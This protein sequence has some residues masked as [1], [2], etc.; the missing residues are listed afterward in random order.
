MDR[1][2][3]TAVAFTCCLFAQVSMAQSNKY[4][5]SSG[6]MEPHS[7]PSHSLAASIPMTDDRNP[8]TFHKRLALWSLAAAY[9]TTVMTSAAMDDDFIGT[10]ALPVAGPW[11][12]MARI[13][14]GQGYYTN[15]GK[16]LLAAA[17]LVQGGL[18][19]YALVSWAHESSYVPRVGVSPTINRPGFSVAIRF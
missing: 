3:T 11:I 18:L 10:T 15:G 4:D 14:S 19:I 13:E 16:P 7:T 8:Y 1:C 12:T 6:I 5:I 17:G 9:T 2:T